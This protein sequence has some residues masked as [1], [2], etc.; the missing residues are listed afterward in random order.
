MG[1]KMADLFKLHIITP[2]KAFYEG[3]A[4]MVEL[5]TTE[6]N[7]G[8]YKNHVPMTLIVAPGVLR[9]HEE[10]GNRE[11]A[12]M[13]GFIQILPEE[14]TIMAEVAEWPEDI[15]VDRAKEAKIRAERRISQG[16]GGI[17]IARAELALRKALVRLEV[18]G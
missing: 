11:A 7:I 1:I 6:G 3:D 10:G 15:D 2:E 5:T 4:S 8:V 13:S 17:D 14:I 18:K 16:S 12:L 9:I